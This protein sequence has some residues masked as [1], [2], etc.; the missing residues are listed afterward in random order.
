MD[1]VWPSLR[2]DRP[3]PYAQI[4]ASARAE[5]NRHIPEIISAFEDAMALRGRL[6]EDAFKIAGFSGRKF[7]YFLNNLVNSVASPAYL[8]IGLYFGASFCPAIYNNHVRAVGIDNWTEHNGNSA[9][10]YQ[11]LERYKQD[12]TDVRIIESD[13]RKVD[14]NSIG[15]FNILF[16]D[17]S[18]AEKDQYDGVSIPQPAMEDKYILIVDDW[19]WDPVRKGTFDAL[20]DARVTIDYQI[21]VRTTFDGSIPLVRGP[22]SEWH[23]GTIVAAVSKRP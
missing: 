19:N 7:R 15:K 5:T 8:E 3:P 12:R 18:H 20:R 11:N 21:E 22:G 4:T 10:F 17:G 16:Y 9:G 1:T 23:N 14:F 2:Q 6:K 13:F